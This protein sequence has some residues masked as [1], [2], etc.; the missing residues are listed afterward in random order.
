MYK[1]IN[2][3]AVLLDAD[4]T[5]FDNYGG[6]DGGA[7][8]STGVNL[9]TQV[10]TQDSLS[11]EMKEFYDKALIELAKPE[12]IH[13]RFA[14][15]K[16]IPPN[17][18]DTIEF[19]KFDNL[20][21]I[22]TPLVEGITPDGQ[23]LAVSK[24]TAHVDQFG[25]Y[26]TL[27]DKIKLTAVDPILNVAVKKLARQAGESLDT[28]D[29]ETLNGGTNVILAQNSAGQATEARSALYYTSAADNCNLKVDDIKRAVRA[30]ER[31]DAPK[32]DGYYM[33]IIHPDVAYDLMKDPDWKDPKTYVDTKDIYENELGMLYGVRFFKNTRAKVFAGMD[34]ESQKYYNLASDSRTLAI[35][36][37]SG[38]TGA[39]TSVA[40]DG[41]TVAANALVGRKIMINGVTATVT[42]NTDSAITFAST[43]FGSITDNT[44][45]YPGEGGDDGVPVFSTLIIGEDAYA[46]VEIEG[47][48]MEMIVKPLGSGGTSDPINQRSTAGW[49]AMHVSKILVPQYIVRIESTATP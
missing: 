38:Y 41:G 19:H 36:Y 42:A 15:K 45:I 10:T 24:I 21:P 1:T 18:G 48:G 26:V 39:I 43:N 7:A 22:T 34:T 5:L 6:T 46:T 32:I 33:A 29:R 9:N 28:L 13:A 8:G 47:G 40:F 25:G 11:P 44:V 4:L 35:N 3:F 49:K 30:L 37:A 2:P 27:S 20:P 12:L 14:Q 16:K 17:N 31:Q 23:S